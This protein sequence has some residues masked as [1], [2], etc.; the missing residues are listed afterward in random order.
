MDHHQAALTAPL[1]IHSQNDS[2]VMTDH[3]AALSPT[4]IF[5]EEDGSNVQ[6]HVEDENTVVEIVNL[7]DDA[8]DGEEDFNDV[9]AINEIVHVYDDDNQDVEVE[10]Q[11]QGEEWPC[12]RCTLLNPLRSSSCEACQFVRITLSSSSMNRD[13]NN[14]SSSSSRTQIADHVS[15]ER[16]LINDDNI[17]N[18]TSFYN[19]TINPSLNNNNTPSYTGEGVIL[20]SFIGAEGA[21]VQ[22]RSVQAGALHDAE[23]G[24][25]GGAP[26]GE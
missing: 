3:A 14:D 17:M 26:V 21:D 22:G 7:A 6:N 10:V 24:A 13:N 9:H 15:Q 11:E 4:I 16:L 20:G 12:P 5:E 23:R 8:E 1:T 19:S 25:V 18:D 2:I